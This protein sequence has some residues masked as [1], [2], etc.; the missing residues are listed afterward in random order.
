MKHVCFLK[1]GAAAVSPHTA[2]HSGIPQ[3][4][5]KDSMVAFTCWSAC[6][7]LLPKMCF[8]LV[9]LACHLMDMTVIIAGISLTPAKVRHHS[10]ADHAE[11]FLQ[12][13]Y[14][15]SYSSTPS[16]VF[17]PCPLEGT[18]HPDWELALL[19]VLQPISLVHC[20]F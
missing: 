10:A 13:P 2:C 9:S 8:I 3:P 6:A 4:A 16:C 1:W 18:H 17:F 14:L 15:C 20:L 11:A 12:L 19:Y 7:L 5:S